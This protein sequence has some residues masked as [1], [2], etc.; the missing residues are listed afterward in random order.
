MSILI[1]GA[2]FFYDSNDVI[3]KVFL[4]FLFF[5]VINGK[6]FN[7]DNIVQENPRKSIL[8]PLSFAKHSTYEKAS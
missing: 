5:F 4:S 3:E 7:C 1:D 8:T 6:T 2:M